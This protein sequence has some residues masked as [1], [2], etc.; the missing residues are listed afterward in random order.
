ME[1]QQ[2]RLWRA[3]LGAQREPDL[4]A[5]LR[6]TLRQ[7]GLAIQLMRKSPRFPHGLR[8]NAGRL[9]KSCIDGERRRSGLPARLVG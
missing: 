4:H 9:R 3:T 2:T 6:E 7:G 1:F 8:V 5:G